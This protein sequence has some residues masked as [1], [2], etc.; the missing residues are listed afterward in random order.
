MDF[1]RENSLY[2][3]LIMG[4]VAGYPLVRN[5]NHEFKSKTGIQVLLRCCLF[6]LISVVSVVMFA[7]LESM[8]SGRGFR[9]SGVS[10]YGLYLIAPVIML[11]LFRE[12]RSSNFDAYAFYIL[13]S[14]VL[15]RIRCLIDGCCIGKTIGNSR[16]SYPTR[17][18]EI[19]FYIFMI[20][21]LKKKQNS[22]K[23]GAV[24]PLVMLSYSLFRF[25]EE[26]MREGVGL[27]HLAHG[28]SVISFVISFSVFVELNRK[29]KVGDSY[30]K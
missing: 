4:I 10:T 9:Y 29:N 11:V 19:F 13:P 20:V 23:R 3:S 7:A 1:L 17:E 26:F 25:V 14:M 27:I 24:F 22:I 15:Q 30:G 2:I 12:N 8:I 16:F 21:A 5:I 28:W 18:L 6:T